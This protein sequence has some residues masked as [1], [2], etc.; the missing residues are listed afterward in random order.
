M[1]VTDEV[2]TKSPDTSMKWEGGT[3]L[4]SS[5]FR[6]LICNPFCGR[7][8]CD[9]KPKNLPPAMPHDQQAVEQTKRDCRDDE[10]IHRRDAGGMIIEK[11][12][13]TLGRRASTP[14]HIL[15][16]ARLPD[17][18]AELE[19]LAVDPR[20]SR[21]RIGNAHLADQ[22]AY[23]HRNNRPTT[24]ASRLPAPVGSEP[25]TMPADKGVR[26]DDRQRI[27]NFR[28]QPIET[29]EYHS[30]DGAEGEFLWSSPP[31]NV[32]LLPQRPN[33]CLKHDPP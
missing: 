15:G 7:M 11:R 31:Q 30:V 24:T 12:F 19:K 22:S 13:P 32:D 3:V 33:L 4:C 1:G 23:F 18:D 6:D 25:G 8:R 20:R 9:A 5:G 26:L 10:Q 16:H 14:G 27:A 2:A 29:N 17:I 21:Q 28:K